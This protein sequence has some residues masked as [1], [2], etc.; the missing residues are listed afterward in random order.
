LLFLGEAL[1]RYAESRSASPSVKAALTTV[2]AAPAHDVANGPPMRSSATSELTRSCYVIDC[3]SFD[4]LRVD[5]F[6]HAFGDQTWELGAD[7]RSQL[8]ELI[9]KAELSLAD[10]VEVFRRLAPSREP[11]GGS[12][13]L[14]MARIIL[15]IAP[16]DLPRFK[17]ALEYDGNYKDIVEYCFQDIDNTT[18]RDEIIRHFRQVSPRV[19]IKVLT[20]VDDT[21]YA[22]LIE[23]RYPKKMLY[24]GVI[25]FYDALKR[26]PF[27]MSAIPL[28]TLSA[29]PNPIAGTIEEAS[30]SG[31][32]EISCGR[33]CP[34]ALSGQFVSAV[35]GTFETFLRAKLT[36]I[37]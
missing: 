13:E 23:G 18:Y 22:N 1:S 7:S 12:E 31:L 16:T 8:D 37:K 14:R 11:T 5:E 3:V 21:M 15:S 27:E 4:S 28:T 34:S 35:L 36:P 24:P 2:E 30:L 29:R 10:K 32:V 9:E 25:E 20:D 17:S 6:M 33:L 26:E 19:G